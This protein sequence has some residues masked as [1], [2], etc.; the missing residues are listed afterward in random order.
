VRADEAYEKIKPDVKKNDDVRKNER[1]QQFWNTMRIRVE[2]NFLFFKENH[3]LLQNA[4]IRTHPSHS[5][6]T[7]S[8]TPN[9]WQKYSKRE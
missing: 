5:R 8:K 2:S 3:K 4:L 7:H 6:G 9:E 1:E